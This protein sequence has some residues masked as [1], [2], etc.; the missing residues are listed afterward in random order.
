MSANKPIASLSLDLD[1]QWSYMQ[2]H[3][4]AGWESFPSYLDIFV[5]YV[6]EVLDDLDLRITFFIVGQDAALEKNRE[7]LR[8][9]VRRGHEVGNHSFRH[10]SWLHTY[11]RE[12]LEEEVARAETHIERATGQRPTGFRGPGFSWSPALLEVLAGRG[13]RYDASTLPTY[14]GPLAR[15]YYFWTADLSPEEK[16][17]RKKLF[18]TFRDGLRPVKPYYW[19][20]N[21]RQTM[22]E[23]PVTTIPVIKTPFHFSYLLYLSGFSMTLADTYLD[24]AI[25]LCKLTGTR[26]S[27]LLHPLDLIGGDEMP[28]LRFFPGMDIPSERKIEVFRRVI[29]RLSRSFRL[30]NM[31]E[32]VGQL[33]R[34]QLA[35]RPVQK[36][37]RFE[38]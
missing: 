32:H 9:I 25:R 21:N 8:E 34:E 17:T 12:E 11:S 36:N 20:L 15:L 35:V 5:P 13:Y 24:L 1:N 37:G 18:G 4:D 14:I 2:I 26:P 27:Y 33:S 19:Q 10:E 6:L 30:V 29:G 7:Y 28:A 23:V 16:A 38:V 22:L 3:G 31:S